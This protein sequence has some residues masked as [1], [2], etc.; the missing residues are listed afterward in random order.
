MNKIYL[1]YSAEVTLAV[2]QNGKN[3]LNFMTIRNMRY[4]KKGIIK[5]YTRLM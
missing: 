5:I 2:N 3:V 1:Y 4:V